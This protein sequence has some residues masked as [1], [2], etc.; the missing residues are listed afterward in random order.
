MEIACN[1]LCARVFLE[2]STTVGNC[3][4]L[5]ECLFS[6]TLRC[7][8]EEVSAYILEEVAGDFRRDRGMS[9]T[10]PY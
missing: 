6:R 10:S 4:I 5:G 2:D 9:F 8:L 3:E 1:A 7:R